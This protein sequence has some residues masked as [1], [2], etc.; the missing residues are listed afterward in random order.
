MNNNLHQKG[1]ENQKK[2]KKKIENLIFFYVI[3]INLYENYM[4]TNLPAKCIL[5]LK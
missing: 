3:F 4:Q 5:L 1:K 2:N